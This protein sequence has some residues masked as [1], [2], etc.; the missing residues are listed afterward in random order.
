VSPDEHALTG[1]WARRRRYLSADI[2]HQL[3]NSPW[4]RSI[5]DEAQPLDG[6]IEVKKLRTSAFFGTALETYLRKY[7]VE[8]V[9]LA[10]VALNGAVI[11]TLADA[12]SRDFYCLVVGDASIGTTSALHSAA[13]A[14]IGAENVISTTA[15]CEVWPGKHTAPAPSGTSNPDNGPM[16]TSTSW[17]NHA[18]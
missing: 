3:D 17:M 16:T 8:T 15:L 2:A 12:V 13:L 18:N 1:P 5:V 14:V 10:G 4:G 7:Q 9:L 11:A 6:E